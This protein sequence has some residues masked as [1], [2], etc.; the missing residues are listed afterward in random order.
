MSCLHT[1]A[2]ASMSESETFPGLS[3]AIGRQ[4]FLGFVNSPRI[5]HPKIIATPTALNQTVGLIVAIVTRLAA[6]SSVF[7]LSFHTAVSSLHRVDLQRKRKYT[8]RFNM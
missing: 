1:V 6:M 7:V 4:S 3:V 8:D 2:R 5:Y